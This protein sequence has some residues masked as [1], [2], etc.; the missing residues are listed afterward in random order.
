MGDDLEAMA[1]A[2]CDAEGLHPSNGCVDRLAA[3]LRAVRAEGERDAFD[4]AVLFLR[5]G[6]RQYEAD[7]LAEVDWREKALRDARRARGAK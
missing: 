5:A 4:A 2:W 1:R 6:S 7:Q 3:L